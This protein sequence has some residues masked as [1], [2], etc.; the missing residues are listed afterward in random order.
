MQ[1][2]RHTRQCRKCS[3]R[4]PLAEFPVHSPATGGRRHECHRCFRERMRRHYKENL[5]KRLWKS[6]LRYKENPLARWTPERRERARELARKRNTRLRDQVVAGYGGK[7]A[8][9]GE[10]EK[11]FLT[12][13]HVENNG[14]EMR[15]NGH[16]KTSHGLYKWAIK[17]DFPSTLQVLCMNCN[18]GKARNGGICPH[19]E[20]STTRASARTAKRREVHHT[21]RG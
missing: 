14:A 19:Q 17:N 7:C 2:D 8:C 10:A 16:G 15:R 18:F 12:I 5:N 1:S 21:P 4:F 3:K 13:D 9:C 11:L 20:G 6:R